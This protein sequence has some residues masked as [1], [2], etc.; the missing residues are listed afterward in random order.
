MGEPVKAS[1]IGIGAAALDAGKKPIEHNSPAMKYKLSKVKVDPEHSVPGTVPLRRCRARPM[2][3][4]ILLGLEALR[5]ALHACAVG[6]HHL[7]D[8]LVLRANDADVGA[9][10]VE[11][12]DKGC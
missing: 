7:G 3:L 2:E 12:G 5:T 10:R 8:D 4:G 11:R 9:R 1:G 6:E